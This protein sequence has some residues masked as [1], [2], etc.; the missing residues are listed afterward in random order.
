MPFPVED[1]ETRWVNNGLPN[2]NDCIGR[3][4][5]GVLLGRGAMSMA[6][7]EIEIWT[8][9]VLNLDDRWLEIVNALDENGY[10]LHDT[11]P[12]GEFVHCI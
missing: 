2:I 1:D 8:R 10:E 6:G 4:I 9:L 11:M 12:T 5:A 3:T 7:R